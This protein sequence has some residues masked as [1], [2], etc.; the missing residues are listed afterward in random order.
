[1]PAVRCSRCGSEPVGKRRRFSSLDFVFFDEEKRRGS[2]RR[3][4]ILIEGKDKGKSAALDSNGGGRV[5]TTRT[6]PTTW[7]TPA[8]R[9]RHRQ[10][11]SVSK[12]SAQSPPIPQPR[13]LEAVSACDSEGDQSSAAPLDRLRH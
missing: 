7:A 11:L 3:N 6:Q 13:Q 4:R 8:G 12:S 1:M 2:N 9:E 5:P 10:E